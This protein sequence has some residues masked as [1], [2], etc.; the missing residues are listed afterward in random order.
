VSEE[1]KIIDE[2]VRWYSV[3]LERFARD[4]V[5]IELRK[6]DLPD[7]NKAGVNLET[8][9]LVAS[10]TIWGWGDLEVI[11][12]CKRTKETILADDLSVTSAEE[13]QRVLESY[14]DRLIKHPP[15]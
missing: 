7:L 1:E 5:M 14:Y 15:C 11:V 10:I 6:S 2:F 4:A 13:L 3:G 9:Y 12:V 8:D